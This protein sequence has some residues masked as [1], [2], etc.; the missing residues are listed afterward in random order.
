[1]GLAHPEWKNSLV[2]S[3]LSWSKDFPIG[4][5]TFLKQ[6]LALAAIFLNFMACSGDSVQPVPLDLLIGAEDFPGLAV[7]ATGGEAGETT[8]AEP[9]AQV[10]LTGPG[11]K[12]LESLVLFETKDQALEI[13]AGIK[14][15]MAA[16]GTN[17]APVDGF[18]DISGIDANSSLD[19]EPASTLFFVE[20]RALVRLTVAGPDWQARI[21]DLSETARDKASRQ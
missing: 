12:L 16:L 3:G 7:T 1:M 13:L 20:D 17:A 15:D 5:T 8:G 18:Q 2:T 6:A 14:Q 10:E 4:L 9:A 21:I 19:G 11:F